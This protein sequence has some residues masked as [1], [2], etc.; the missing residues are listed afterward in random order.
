MTTRPRFVLAILLSALVAPAPARAQKKQLVVALNQ[1]PD[2][3]DP[4]LSQ[5]YVGRI[6]FAN[7]CEKLYE[8]D[9]NLTSPAARRRA[10]AV[11]DGGRTVSIKLRSGIKFNDGTPMNAEAMK[12]S[13]DR[14][15]EIKGSNRRS[16]LDAGHR[17][18]G[19]RSADGPAAPEGAVRARW[20]PRWP[21]ARACRCRPTQAE[22]LGDKFGT[23]PVCVGPWQFVERVPQDR[24]V[25]ERAPHYYDPKS[26]N[27]DRLVFRIIP[28]D[29]VRGR[30]LS[31]IPPWSPRLNLKRQSVSVPAWPR[32]LRSTS[33]RG[34]TPAPAPP[35]TP[36]PPSPP[37]PPA[38]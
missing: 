36:P 10:A 14:H 33:P 18:R 8:I 34:P 28:D 32:R 5:T 17:R 26:V 22:K 37:P 38:P 30:Q 4:T 13:L 7:M 12:Y 23:A 35:A 16:E 29:N 19:G 31:H 20:W 6:I 3:L 11:S 25:L 15:R 21:T 9:E 1:D 27:F 24:I 2:I